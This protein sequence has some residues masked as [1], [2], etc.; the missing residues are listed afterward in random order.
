M[1]CLVANHLY[2]ERPWGALLLTFEGSFA[3]HEL[4]GESP[5]R[6]CHCL[7]AALGPTKFMGLV[8]VFPR[9]VDRPIEFGGPAAVGEAV[10]GG[11]DGAKREKREK[12]SRTKTA[13]LHQSATKHATAFLTEHERPS[14][15]KALGRGFNRNSK[16]DEV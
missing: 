10:N 8:A 2:S 9:H 16:R 12:L 3:V 14:L 11:G 5:F 6:L 13:L 15:S 1:I 4:L 7:L